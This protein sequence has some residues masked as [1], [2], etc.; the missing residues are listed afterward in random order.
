MQL[1][2]FILNSF[3]FFGVVSCNIY[4]EKKI[5]KNDYEILQTTFMKTNISKIY[6]SEK[7]DFGNDFTSI[8][9]NN[10]ILYN[11]ELKDSLRLSDYKFDLKLF[12]KNKTIDWSYNNSFWTDALKKKI[13]ID[14]EFIKFKQID[15]QNL[16]KTNPLTASVSCPIYSDDFTIA[17]V[18]TTIATPINMTGFNTFLIFKKI[19]KKWVEFGK[20]S[21]DAHQM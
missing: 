2:K 3:L 19:K 12:R 9:K 10:T 21:M 18:K 1:R 8:V 11:E 16:L 14:K 5:E 20:I 13:I 6:L 7:R 4:E 17:I 15:S